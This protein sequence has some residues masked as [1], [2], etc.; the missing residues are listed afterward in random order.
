MTGRVISGVFCCVLLQYVGENYH[1]NPD[2]SQQL[3]R[4]L[5]IFILKSLYILRYGMFISYLL[6][7][8][9]F[10]QQHLLLPLELLWVFLFV[11]VVVVF[12]I[13]L[14]FLWLSSTRWLITGWWNRLDFRVLWTAEDGGKKR[15]FLF[16]GRFFFFLVLSVQP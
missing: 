11:W 4:T 5:W 16:L 8:F 15:G 12:F 9:H 10:C 3:N 14:F 13:Y 7:C 6:I 2:K 1:L